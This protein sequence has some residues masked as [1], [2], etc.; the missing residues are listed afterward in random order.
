MAGNLITPIILQLV[1]VGVIIAEIIL[2][3]GGILSI[4]AAGLFGYSIY[5][6]FTDVSTAA[7]VFFVAADIITIPIILIVGLKM[8][9]KSPV[10]LKKTLSDANGV[11]SQAPELQKYLEKE[12]VTVTDLRPAGMAMIDGNKVD[13]VSRGEY[14]EKDIKVIVSE[15]TGNQIIVRAVDDI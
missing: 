13:V 12:G 2:P 10:T 6:V 7:G 15:I 14:I 4:L 5:M 9:A 1:G 11:T 3:S 8:L